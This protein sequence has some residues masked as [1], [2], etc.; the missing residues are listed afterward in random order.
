M[1]KFRFTMALQAF[2]VV[3]IFLI[4]ILIAYS[5]QDKEYISYSKE[6]RKA[7]EKYVLDKKIS[8]KFNESYVIF[9]KDLLD[10]EYI[11][12]NNDK[13]CVYSV[14]YTRGIIKKFKANK[15]CN[16]KDETSIE[17]NNT[18]KNET[19]ETDVIN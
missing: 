3:G 12:K 18:E 11:E 13:F 5:N 7:C 6:V 10:E 15:D 9:I 4:I 1:N 14:T 16:I 19:N 2:L 8:L 17:E